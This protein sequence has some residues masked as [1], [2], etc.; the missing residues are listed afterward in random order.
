MYIL[1]HEGLLHDVIE[2]KMMGKAMRGRKRTESL[3]NIM[4]NK[5]CVQLKE[6]ALSRIAW[7]QEFQELRESMS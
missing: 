5:N 6:L 3:H 4:E 1:R 2:G 7:I